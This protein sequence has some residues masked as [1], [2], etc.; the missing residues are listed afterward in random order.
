MAK[1]RLV[2]V[3][4][5]V[6]SLS[7]PFVVPGTPAQAAPAQ[8]TQ[9]AR[10]RFVHASFDA[11]T[12]DGYLDGAAVA[13]G[14][15]ANSGYMDVEPGEH[16]FSWRAAGGAEDLAS[17]S[18]TIESG[19]RVTI[20]AMNTFANLEARAYLDDVSA[21]PRYTARVRVVHAVP[22]AGPV[23][24]TAG[25]LTLASGLN[26]GEVGVTP[27]YAG[28]HDVIVTGADGAQLTANP[29]QS[30]LDERTYTLFVVGTAAS[31]AFR[32]VSY[33]STVLPLEPTSL[34]RFAHMASGAGP[35]NVHFNK[36]PAPLY[37]G[38]VFGNV[39]NSF[40]A[41]LGTH[42]VELYAPGT[43]PANAAPLA[44]GTF[45]I[46]LNE[47]V[48]FVAQGS[49]DALEV[50]AYTAD[51]SPVPSQS[52]RLTVINLATG[53]PP[54]TV[55]RMN[56]TPL[57]DAIDLYST[58]STIVP[59][60][61]YNIRFKNASSGVMMMEK[62]SIGIPVGTVTMMIA[63]DDDPS[64][65][66]VNVVT[67][68]NEGVPV[69]A[70]VRWAHFNIFGPP[71]T[72]TMNGAPA[73]ESLVYRMNTE[74]LLYPPGIYTLETYPV[75]ADPSTS[76]PLSSMSVELTGDNFPRTIYVYGDPDQARLNVT[77]DSLELLPDGL[78]RIRF[79]NAAIDAGGV[80][81]YNSAD[82]ALVAQSVL[83]GQASSNT[84]LSAGTYSFTFVADFGQVAALQAFN[85]EA[86]KIY[87]VVLGG[88]VTEQP[89]AEVFVL[90]ATP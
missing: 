1:A 41:G 72:V 50:G 75:G 24:V 81:V 15:R 35:V 76:E 36:E 56:G 48:L 20:A 39:Q 88:S 66:W 65:P 57:L 44:S 17:T 86:G 49:A 84:N 4:M 78:A 73:V 74:Y 53:N 71:V 69:Y 29:G 79:I 46:G 32:I 43:N 37:S 10:V 70:A 62:G 3:L 54:F 26:Y 83:F 47:A 16:T 51:Y 52:A 38:V 25:D 27:V 8:Q 80:S 2:L 11:P 9:S 60:G 89:G 82:N 7:L 23:T 13:P 45:D 34:F 33:E 87:T 67:V 61:S 63:F 14:V 22:D 68:P 55:E 21:P 5:L 40:V 30:F 42:L 28:P 18:L 85:V 6:L 59:A 77:P 58:A 90:T 64:D 12:L 31:G 19:Q